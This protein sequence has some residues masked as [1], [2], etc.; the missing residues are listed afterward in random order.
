MAFQGN[1][2]ASSHEISTGRRKVLTFVVVA[3]FLALAAAPL[4]ASPYWNSALTL[5]LIN[6]L[7]IMGFRVI[8]TM[9]GWSFAQIG[10]AGVG[11]YITGLLSTGTFSVPIWLTFIVSIIAGVLVSLLLAFPILRTRNYNFFLA[12][13]AAGAALQQ[14]AFQFDGLT[15]GTRG[16]AF[17]PRPEAVAGLSFESA[18]SFYYLT[19]VSALLVGGALIWFDQARFGRTIKAVAANEPLC[20]SLGINTKA[21]RTC[22]F[23]LGSSIASFAG[24][25]LATFNG[26]I[27]PGDFGAPLMFKIA[28]SAIVGGVTTM[29]GPLIGLLYI[30]FIEEAFRRSAQYIPLLWGLSVILV[31]LLTKGGLETLLQRGRQNQ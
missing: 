26:A 3:V 17:I 29:A 5:L 15:G 7:I 2:F 18:T 14:A 1:I 13:F 9:G 24:S 10:I 21:W 16:V 8:T 25:L 23:V 6:A 27:T 30:T 11:A 20:E 19:L 12:T 31:L 28:A 4:I 22:A